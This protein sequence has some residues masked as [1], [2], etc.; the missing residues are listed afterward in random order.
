MVRNSSIYSN[1]YPQPL[2]NFYIKQRT[3]D[4]LENTVILSPTGLTIIPVESNIIL[5]QKSADRPG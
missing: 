5:E 2:S 4:S 3:L 1:T